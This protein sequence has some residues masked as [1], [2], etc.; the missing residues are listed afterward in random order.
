MLVLSRVVV[1]GNSLIFAKLWLKLGGRICI[2]LLNGLNASVGREQCDKI[3]RN[4][5]TLATKIK[6]LAIIWQCF[7]P[8]LANFPCCK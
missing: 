4:F 5:A 1:V 6:S 3:W 2:L 8:T 7:E